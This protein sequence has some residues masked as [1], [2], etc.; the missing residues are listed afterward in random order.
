MTT[1]K[2]HSCVS[3]LYYAGTERE[4]TH[5]MTSYGRTDTH[6]QLFTIGEALPSAC[7]GDSH[8]YVCC[9]VSVYV[10]CVT[11]TRLSITKISIFVMN[12]TSFSPQ[13]VCVCVC[14]A[15]ALRREGE[16]PAPLDTYAHNHVNTS[17]NCVRARGCLAHWSATVS[18]HQCAQI[19]ISP[20]V[21]LHINGEISY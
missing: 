13:T 21:R 8:G 5:S 19:H 12:G 17:R 14:A 4:N 20:P 3:I 9:G 11:L 18:F 15:R 6:T 7:T 10:L 16:R 2:R 1:M